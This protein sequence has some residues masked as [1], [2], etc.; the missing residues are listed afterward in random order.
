M[1]NAQPLAPLSVFRETIADALYPISA[2]DLPAACVAVG[3]QEQRTPGDSAEAF[4]SKMRYVKKLI[5]DKTEPQLLAIA[6]AVLH[7][8]TAP[9]LADMVS[10][11]T[12]HAQWRLTDVTRRDVLK[13]L[14]LLDNLFEDVPVFVGLNIIADPPLQHS[15][16]DV[17]HSLF[18]T[19]L[20]D[21][22]E[23]HYLQ[24]PDFSHEHA[25]ILCGALTCSQSRF[26]ALL[27][28]LVDP[29]VRRGPEQ[30]SL[31]E[32][33]NIVL[34]R[35]GFELVIAG[36][37]S[38]YPYYRMRRTSRPGVGGAMKN[39]IFAS[40]GPKPEIILRD[41]ISNDVEIVKNADLVLVY[42]RPLV[43]ALTWKEM[44]DWW[45]AREGT[46]DR[47]TAKKAL[48]A[49]MIE[50]VRATQSPGELVL[51]EAYHRALGRDLQEALPFMVPQ[52][53]L[54]FDPLTRRQRGDEIILNRQRMDFLLLL[55]QSARIVLEVDGAHH[56][57]DSSSVDAV[58]LVASPSR[59]GAMAFEDRRLKLAGY[60]VFR[61]GAAEFKLNSVGEVSPDI[62]EMLATF[63]RGL[64]QKYG[65]SLVEK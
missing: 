57:A 41:A 30:L 14:N 64:L 18:G 3:I 50:A 63:F 24:N 44:L 25:L 29:E 51:F 37:V 15:S 62:E 12:E 61:F 42:D 56:Y 54:H 65:V 36:A 40:T 10:E 23:Q 21:D 45:Q 19:T 59:Y 31:A 6:Q 60:E 2:H 1:K 7:E 55:E 20:S 32:A 33:M 49:R 16:S 38:G 8:Y 4:S 39:L 5:A 9:K 48:Y 53:Y 27:E 47:Q 11:R 17:L 28:R 13:R 46:T 43:A 22:L 26:F 35:D 52:V 34:R 58:Q